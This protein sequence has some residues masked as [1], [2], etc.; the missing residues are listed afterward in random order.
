MRTR[1]V[2]YTGKGGVGKTSVA[3]AT[4]LLCAERGLRTL[5]ISTDVAHSLGDAFD[6]KVANV[7]TRLARGLWAQETDAYD[8][9]R[10]SWGAIQEYFVK[11][12]KWRGLDEIRAEEM[13]VI[14][15]LD[16]IAS[17]LQIV[18]HVDSG[19][20]DIV[21]VDA[22]PTGETV[23]LLSFPEAAR[24]WLERILPI[25]RR[26]T[27]LA[28]PML[29]RV[30]T[31][32]LPEDRFFRSG[33]DLFRKLDRMNQLLGDPETTSLRIV[34]NLEKM[35]I[36]E[37]LRSFTYFH[38]FG[39]V[40]DLVVCNRVLPD[41]AGPYFAAWHAAQR[42]YLHQ[43]KESFAPVPVRE[44]PFL[45]HE[46]AGVDTLREVGATLFGKDDPAAFYY[47][48]RPY[49]VERENGGFALTLEL[50]FASRGDLDIRRSR[51]EL[52]VHVGSW[53][54]NLILPR[55]LVDVPTRDAQLRDGVLRVY[56]ASA[57]KH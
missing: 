11:V 17:L 21:V 29:R 52:V 16:E 53:R 23:R 10:A 43:V 6:R 13:T 8:A 26:A 25:Q 30:T 14:P 2:V 57:K 41:D 39:Y 27:R 15:G 5:V 45:P 18:D 31:M 28:R 35:V 51:E 33:E 50:P 22:A 4:A 19:R 56:F 3:A 34:L 9:I 48:G 7:P 20:Y 44:V 42:G 54:R 24:W 47:K 37:A 40:T 38:L 49:R 36:A 1:V 12:F 46:V 55:I 32:P